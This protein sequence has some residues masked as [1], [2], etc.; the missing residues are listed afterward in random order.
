MQIYKRPNHLIAKLLL[1][2]AG[3]ARLSS[4]HFRRAICRRRRER[5]D[6]PATDAFGDCTAI[7]TY[8]LGWK[9]FLPKTVLPVGD[10]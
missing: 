4:L 9:V 7:I 1:R 3:K 6:M 8:F 2:M 10:W 5:S